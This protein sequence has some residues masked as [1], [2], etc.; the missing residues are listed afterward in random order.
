MRKLLKIPHN[1]VKCIPAGAVINE[2]NYQFYFSPNSL[3]SDNKETNHKQKTKQS[4]DLVFNLE[5]QQ[6]C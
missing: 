2:Y 3:S 6:H 1:L 5:P 4:M